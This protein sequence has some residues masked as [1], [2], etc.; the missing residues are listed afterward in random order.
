MPTEIVEQLETLVIGN[1][2]VLCT[3]QK[4]MNHYFKSSSDTP[5]PK[6][7]YKTVADVTKDI[8]IVESLSDSLDMDAMELD[9][10][11]TTVVSV[12]VSALLRN[13]ATPGGTSTPK[14]PHITTSTP[15]VPKKKLKLNAAIDKVMNMN[16]SAVSSL[17]ETDSD[18]LFSSQE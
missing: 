14:R 11:N 8:S 10:I 2:F 6:D 18:S 3:K 7:K 13:E 15:Q 9:S 5:K 12:A 4:Q 1:Q 17:V 16:D